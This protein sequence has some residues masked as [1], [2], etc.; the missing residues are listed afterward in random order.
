MT[1]LQ[2]NAS[3]DRQCEGMFI[4]KPNFGEKLEI[5]SHSLS[6]IFLP[7][8]TNIVGIFMKSVNIK[9]NKILPVIIW[10]PPKQLSR[11]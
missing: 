10:N 6:V 8:D 9:V 1:E 2:L 3:V 4:Y 5:G 7:S 11:K